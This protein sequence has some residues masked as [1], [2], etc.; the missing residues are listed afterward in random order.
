MKKWF[1]KSAA[2]VLILSLSVQSAY[3][4]IVFDN[5]L[6]LQNTA[7]N[8]WV[9]DAQA[10]VAAGGNIGLQFGKDSV[11]TNNGLLNW[12]SG[13]SKSFEIDHP[14]SLGQNQIR[15]V[16]LEML[17]SNPGTPT[18]G[19]IYYNT[20][21]GHPWVYDGFA[22]V[23]EDIAAVSA[24]A[25]KVVSVGPGLDFASIESAAGYLNA[26]SGGIMLLSAG[27]HS[28]TNSVNLTNI[29]MIGKDAVK[30]TLSI[31]G[32]G[33]ID[34][35]DT[36][37]A[38]MT[39]SVGTINKTMALDMQ[40]GSSS[41]YLQWVDFSIQ[42][43]GTVLIDSESGIPP[44]V[45]IKIV[46]ST[47]TGGSGTLLKTKATANLNAASNLYISSASGNGLVQVQDWNVTVA[48]FGNIYSTGTISTI[49]SNTIY[50]Y[51][52]MNLQGAINSLSGGGSLT[53][54]PGTHSITAPLLISTGNIQISGYGDD[55]VIAASGFAGATVTTAAIQV[56]AANGTASVNQVTLKNFKLTVSGDTTA[57]TD[58]HGIR[59]TGGSDHTVDNVTV[60]KIAGQSGSA[61]TARMGIQMLDGT[62][63]QLI[64]PRIINSR[65]FGNG[66]SNYFT[67]GI[68]VTS[69]P[70][71]AG[72]FGYNSGITDAYVEGNSVDYVR[73]TA[74]VFCGVVNSS[75]SNNRASRMG[76]IGGGDYGIYLGNTSNSKMD[77]NVFS[78]TL[79]TTTVAIGIES[80]A[81]GTLKETKDSVFSNNIV[82]GAGNS[83]VG[84]GTGFQ[85]GNATNT[86][87]HRNTF[88]NNTIKGASNAGGTEAFVVRG[89]A[90]D[91][92]FADND[93]DGGANPWATGIDLQSAL[94][95]RNIIS[96]N[97]YNNVTTRIAD[98][99]SSTRI[100]V[101]HREDSN[102][103]V[104][105]DR[106]LGYYIGTIWVNTSTKVSFISVSDAAG[107]AVWHAV[108]A[109]GEKYK[110][111]NIG[112]GVP[113]SATQGSIAGG[114]AAVLLFDGTNSSDS[115]W[116]FPIPEDWQSGTNINV[117]VFWSPSTA[118]AGN[119]ELNCSYASIGTGTV[120][121]AGGY[122]ALSSGAIA[123]PGIADRLVT[124]TF[125]MASANLAAN[126]MVN[127][128]II[129]NPANVLDT[130]A[131]DAN[132]QKI[133]I[134]YTGKKI[135]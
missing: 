4:A 107:A 54:L 8:K 59:F 74:Y 115:S 53:L 32:D 34:S 47:E 78:G 69:D 26:R 98:V 1:G 70:S 30:T 13:V 50:V 84:F 11:P 117:D 106:T 60:Q 36:S 102:P 73:E 90:D 21:N 133:R 33:H 7:P 119:V 45:V 63:A 14:V 80:F 64:R 99:G 44:T 49:P 129:R 85:I 131:G 122:T 111:L 91:N 57:V 108:D 124:T 28:L 125:T 58:I 130:Y 112:A 128:K 134:R 19:Q 51:P 92:L 52:G 121:A 39:I 72:V 35:F 67:D 24:T 2:L 40:P 94:Q 118:A 15:N 16:G 31:T 42:D 37:F 101:M 61:G 89:N 114:N 103:T 120:V 132:I 127:V 62:A 123:T 20:T 6:I 126:R 82:D 105:D 38:N 5:D 95:E 3:A 87:V 83:G 109:I 17:A 12:N 43:S 46:N 104:N 65:V 86:G 23:W 76:A 96:G 79:G 56:G 9:I 25:D 113:T 48:G 88:Q 18:G 97:R 29:T 100:G 110:W 41:V 75:L 71:I 55:S 22:S 135:Q 77:G 10:G 93:I 116:S 66:G 68:H 81:P 27:T